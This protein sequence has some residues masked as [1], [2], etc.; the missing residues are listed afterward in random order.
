MD[1]TRIRS[2]LI[3]G[4]VIWWT[5]SLVAGCGTPQSSSLLPVP[6]ISPVSP[7]P[8]P[9]LFLLEPTPTSALTPT[10]KPGPQAEPI[11]L[12]VLHT[13]DNWGETAPCG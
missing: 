12:V 11:R 5:V 10:P 3:W 1:K 4:M 9:T 6:G 13:N 7:L 8:T 2:Y